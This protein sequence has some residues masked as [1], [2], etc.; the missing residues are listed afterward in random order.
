M[1]TLLQKAVNTGFIDLGF[2]EWIPQKGLQIKN[3]E[4]LDPDA[5][6]VYIMH[7]EGKIQKVGKSSASLFRRLTGYKRFDS[8]RLAHPVTGTDKTSQRQR[9]AIDKFGLPG[10]TV[11]VLQAEMGLTEFKELGITTRTASFDS[12]ELE[13][14]LLELAKLE[15]HPLEFGS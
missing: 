6:G 13:K 11:W 5:P 14:K 7:H 1:T 12:H 3:L 15:G 2:A 9:S 4:T 10:L 8:D